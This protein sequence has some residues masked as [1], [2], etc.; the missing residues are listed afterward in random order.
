MEIRISPPTGERLNGIFLPAA[1]PRAR[2][3][4]VSREEIRAMSTEGLTMASHV[5]S[6]IKASETPTAMASILV[7]TAKV[8][9]TL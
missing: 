8:N 3:Q 4:M 7:A 9:M 5:F 6:P 1:M 2:P